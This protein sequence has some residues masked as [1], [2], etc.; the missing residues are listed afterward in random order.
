MFAFSYIL[1][2]CLS[3]DN[4]IGS[5]ATSYGGGS[6]DIYYYPERLDP[7]DPFQYPLC[8]V[9]GPYS[10][11]ANLSLVIVGRIPSDGHLLESQLVWSDGAAVPL[12]RCVE[13]RRLRRVGAARVIALNVIPKCAGPHF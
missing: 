2:Y 8:R 5:T 7:A 11:A 1:C 12:T 3:S 10:W 6:L 9:S 13:L 4:G